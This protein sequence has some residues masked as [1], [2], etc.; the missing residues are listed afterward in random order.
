MIFDEVITGFRLA[1]GGAQE[2][3]GVIPDMVTLGKIIGGGFP[4]AAYGGRK[5]IMEMVAPAG[6]VY[7]AGTFSGN[8]ISVA[9][10]LATIEYIKSKREIF[11]ETLESKTNALVEALSDLVAEKNYPLQISHI[12]SMFQIFFTPNPVYDYRSAKTADLARFKTYHRKLLVQKSKTFRTS[13]ANRMK[14]RPDD[15]AGKRPT[16]TP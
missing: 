3:F 16:K 15:E 5:E 11:Y 2:Y 8:P 14:E 6:G 10:G 12:S 4:I 1:L 9:A 13:W 7:Q